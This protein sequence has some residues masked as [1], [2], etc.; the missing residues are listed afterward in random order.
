MITIVPALV[1]GLAATAHCVFMCGGIASGVGCGPERGRAGSLLAA[2]LGRVSM[3]VTAGALIG[4]SIR[5][6]ERFAPPDGLRTVVGIVAAL[7]MIAAAANLAGVVPALAPLE[8]LVAPLWRKVA[9]RAQRLR[10]SRSL[11]GLY[12]FGW[13]WGL[14]PCG[15]VYA[16]LALAAASGSAPLGAATMLAF[17]VGTLPATTAL[18]GAT[19]GLLGRARSPVY[20]RVAAGAL[21]AIAIVGALPTATR[22]GWVAAL[23]RPT[24]HGPCCVAKGPAY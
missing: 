4:G 9:P 10:G 17:G 13:L 3:Y 22:L 2:N 8:R 20:R 7:M 15:A 19:A 14:L 11:I 6:G 23:A 18:G 16:A 21:V 12:A 24:T 5:A 1:A